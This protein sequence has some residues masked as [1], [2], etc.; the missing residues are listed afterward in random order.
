[1][2]QM[3]SILRLIALSILFGGSTTV[4]FVA[5]TLVAAAKAQGV[6]AAEAAAANAP[7]FI[8]YAKIL[9]GAAIALLVA[10]AL[11]LARARKADKLESA[12]YGASLLVIIT[13]FVFSFL[14]VPPMERLLPSI[15]TD[16]AAHGEFTRMHETS[17]IIFGVTILSA[18]ASLIL[19]GLTQQK[20]PE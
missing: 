13:A 3:A 7:I 12:R 4:V 1:M 17:R 19:T 14:I 8:H 18:L 9:I 5:V 11:Q 6:P 15:K 10:E 16:N 2:I 20:K